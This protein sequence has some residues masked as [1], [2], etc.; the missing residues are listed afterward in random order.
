M[1]PLPLKSAVV[2]CPVEL[3]GGPQALHQL[4]HGLNRI[5]VPTVIAYFRFG[6]RGHIRVAGGR[7]I[8]RPV[9]DNPCLEAYAPYEP[10]ACDSFALGPGRLVVMPEI[11]ANWT[12]DF[13]D[14]PRAIWWLTIIGAGNIKG[15]FA[16]P[17]FR[18]QVFR[19]QTLLN[20]A[21]TH[22]L[23][24]ELR[25]VVKGPVVRLSDYVDSAFTA[26][27][28]SAPNPGAT[29]GYNPRKGRGRAARFI[30]LNPDLPLTPIEG[31]A[32]GEVPAA[33]RR[34]RAYVDFSYF[35]GHEL[36]P[37]EAAACGAVV[38][39]RRIRSAADPE[40]YPLD[41]AFKFTDEAILDGTLAA[42]V[43]AVLAD[44]GPAFAAQAGFREA[45]RRERAVFEQ[46][47]AAAFAADASGLPS[48]A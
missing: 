42:A 6:V 1:S 20:L 24:Q 41:D 4:A 29:A 18:Q 39:V 31:L 30:E 44:P 28:P 10:K 9:Q 34:L 12:F 15:R 43:R 25:S 36:M 27:S 48:G 5:G 3:T 8:C 2:A 47:L 26:T 40:D 32:R 23:D 14:S 35:P 33:L 46:Q 38:F 19:D 45:V 22:H 21:A 7:L 16:D 37:R 17:G 13:Q 11:M